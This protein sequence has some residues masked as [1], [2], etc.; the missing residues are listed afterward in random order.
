MDL[1]SI[2]LLVLVFLVFY[3]V[4][5]QLSKKTKKSRDASSEQYQLLIEKFERLDRA[6]K[7][8]L[9]D[10]SRSMASLQA[11]YASAPASPDIIERLDKIESTLKSMGTPPIN[12]KNLD[13]SN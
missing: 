13:A 9:N 1:G 4:F 5:V 10:I 8:E 2:I 7:Y 3:Q 12:A 11:L 6:F